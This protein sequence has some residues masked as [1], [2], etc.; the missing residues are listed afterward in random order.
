MGGVFGTYMSIKS[1]KGP[2]ERA[3]IIRAS[4]ICWTGIT[5]FLLAL[6]L[7]PRPWNFGMWLIYAPALV[8]FIRSTNQGQAIAR[9]EDASGV[10]AEL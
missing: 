3:Y 1:A 10:R 4:W 9:G 6:F 7:I 5:V 8:W 2:R